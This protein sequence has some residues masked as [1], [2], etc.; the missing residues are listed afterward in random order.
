MV[1][2]SP[3][4]SRF[5]S[6]VNLT[7][8]YAGICESGTETVGTESQINPLDEWIFC[9]SFLVAICA[10]VIHWVTLSFGCQGF[11]KTSGRR[12]NEPSDWTS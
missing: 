6:K 9:R 2:C 12:R 4:H 3:Q 8:L 11:S 5:M 10:L 7:D 1:K